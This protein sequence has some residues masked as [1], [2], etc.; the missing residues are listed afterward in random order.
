MGSIADISQKS[1]NRRHSLLSAKKYR[2]Y[3]WCSK[4]KLKMSASDDLLVAE[5]S[6]E[7]PLVE[8]LVEAELGAFLLSCLN[9]TVAW[10]VLILILRVSLMT[11]QNFS[12]RFLQHLNRCLFHTVTERHRRILYLA[13]GWNLYTIGI[14]KLFLRN[15]TI[16]RGF[17]H[18]AYLENTLNAF[19]VLIYIK[20]AKF[21]R[22]RQK[23]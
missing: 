18:L 9:G 8:L 14:Y 1:K 23:S 17:I 10:D 22:R 4:S 16:G 5:W 21:P 3:T 6:A 2:V 13:I 12:S 20:Y 7:S 15:A 11:K 19:G